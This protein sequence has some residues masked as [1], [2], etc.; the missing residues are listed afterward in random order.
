MVV[1]M[2]AALAT[3]T[4][5]H[6]EPGY[7]AV[8]VA[9]QQ[10]G[11][12][13]RFVSRTGI[14][15]S[16]VRR[17]DAATTAFQER[18][19]GALQKMLDAVVGPRRAVVTTA[20]ELDF[21]QVETVTTTYGQDPSVGAL[22][23]R[24]S[25]RSYTDDSGSTRYESTSAVRANALNSLRETRRNAPGRVKKLNIAVLVDATAGQNI[26]LAQL[27][28]L[29]GVAAGV[30][31]GRGDTVA[32]VA[33]PMRPGAVDAADNTLAES[34][35]APAAERQPALPA[36]AVALFILVGVVAG[37]RHRRRA[38]R[39]SAQQDHLQRIR[40]VMGGRRP[41]M[42]TAAIAAPASGRSRDESTERQRQI[43][44]LADDDPGQAAAVLRDWTESG[45]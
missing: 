6:A 28:N 12:D 5:L 9:P 22:S 25:S 33:A 42:D 43:S 37:W 14:A 34:G 20:A 40:A 29:V 3:G 2:V 45:R 8:P 1:A 13:S 36:V 31:P 16:S 38:L 23:E 10:P 30:E 24:L 26:D 21:E 39:M 44:R 7:A 19:N 35:T 27:E 17:N 32:V 41:A 15:A 11:S 18:L 4:C